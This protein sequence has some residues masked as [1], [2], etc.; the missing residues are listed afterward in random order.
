MNPPLASIKFCMRNVVTLFV[1]LSLV[2][3][4]DKKTSEPS[5]VQQR[6]APKAVEKIEE[7]QNPERPV[8]M[9]VAAWV[10]DDPIYELEVDKHVSELTT[11]YQNIRLPVSQQL[12]LAKRRQVLDRLID[13][14]IAK[15]VGTSAPN[16]DDVR[17]YYQQLT[18]ANPVD[19]RARVSSIIMRADI[20]GDAQS[21]DTA[22]RRLRMLVS[23]AKTPSQFAALARIHSKGPTANLGGEIGW[24]RES[25]T[26]AASKAAIFGAKPNSAT[27]VLK[28]P[29]GVQVFWVH[30][31]EE[32][33]SEAY[34]AIRP[35][36]EAMLRQRQMAEVKSR[37]VKDWR[38]KAKIK[39]AERYATPRNPQKDG[40][41]PS[42]STSPREAAQ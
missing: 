29:V 13:Q 5:E 16:E 42:R 36:L 11:L 28:S 4:C 21:I 8:L 27:E 40:G 19:R 39:Y 3:G 32:D 25:D 30:E 35:E 20:P 14:R 24:I 18:D 9:P 41:A 7:P 12:K 23:K 15:E 33:L 1:V 6:P 2:A 31:F 38:A 37:S 34:V 10:N 26:I 22:Q 17:T